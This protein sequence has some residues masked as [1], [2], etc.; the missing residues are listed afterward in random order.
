MC[1]TTQYVGEAAYCDHVG[2]LSD[3]QLLLID[4]PENLRKAAFEGEVVDIELSREVDPSEMAPLSQV[5]GVL[6][7]PEHGRPRV[8]R[9]VV[10]DADE[11]IDRLDDELARSARCR[12]IETREHVVD[13]DE[14][15]V[16]VIERHRSS[17]DDADARS[18]AGHG[19]DRD[20][21]GRPMSIRGRRLARRER[22]E[23]DRERQ[24]GRSCARARTCGRRRRGRRWSRPWRSCARSWSRSS[25]SRSCWCCSCSAR[26]CCCCCSAP[27]TRTRRCRSA[28]S[29]SA[30]RARVYEQAVTEHADDVRRVHRRPGLHQRRGRRRPAAGGRRARRGRRLPDRRPRPDPRRDERHDRG[31]PREARPVPA[32]GDRHRLPARGPGG[33]RL[34]A[35]RDRRRRPAALAPR[36]R[37]GRAR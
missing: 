19:A 10:D 32:G 34:G 2:L 22:R 23:L 17:A 15:F 26:S 20:R 6:S 4:T 29:S 8:W 3:G 24:A 1:V 16:R 27:G 11:A 14:A 18:T 28:P 33:E 30:P 21:G 36:R 9:L 7:G 37:G 13:F 35:E 12:S 5:D 31:P 25:A